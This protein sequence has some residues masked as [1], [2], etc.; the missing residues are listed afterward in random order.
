MSIVEGERLKE[1]LPDSPPLATMW[2]Q[3]TE[4][5]NYWRLLIPARHLPARI[6][7]LL[8]SDTLGEDPLARQEGVA[9]WQFLGDVERTKFAAR[10]QA[11]GV[12]S[13]MEV[14]D[15]YL[16]PAPTSPNM[17]SGWRATV[18]KSFE[19]G[20]T[21]YSHQAHRWI[22]PS[23]DGLI[24]S[25]DELAA[26]YEPL[27][28]A[29][30]HVCP[31]SVELDDWEFVEHGHTERRVTVGYAGSDS[32]YYDLFLVER[33]LD[34]A[35]RKADL[36]K[37]GAHGNNWRWPH[38]IH[39]WTDDL[40][41]YRRNLQ[42]IDIGLCPL[43]RSDW[44]DCKSDIKAMEYVMAGAL[45]IVQA[46]SP[47]FKDWVGIV[48]SASTE[49]QWEKT[50]KDVLSWDWE[51]RHEVWGLAYRFLMGN[52]TIDWHIDKWHTAIAG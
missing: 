34:Y 27:V 8:Y 42:G 43:K 37:M 18:R 21:G 6:N 47:V 12:K 44:H 46:D 40:A 13:M 7:S 25:T 31:N 3:G 29:G 19:R 50:V 30:V 16:I 17:K 51:E 4:G 26:R 32:H 11:A 38:T 2:R 52:K 45:P 9:I 23:I 1:Y 5:T 49:K 33:A 41:E 10:I 48:P 36:V 35:S 22:L 20:E 14:D 39:P 24:C 28:P 15:N